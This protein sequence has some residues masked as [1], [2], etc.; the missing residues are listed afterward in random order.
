MGRLARHDILFEPV[1]IGCKTLR[2]R[3]Y[4]VPHCTGFGVEKPWSQSRHRAVKAQGGWAAVCTEYCTIS[5]E[6]DETPFVSARM[7]DDHDLRMLSYTADQQAT[8][9]WK[10]LLESYEDPGIDP[11]I[12]AELQ[13]YIVRR[14]SEIEAE[15]AA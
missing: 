9:E 11:A 8:G 7:W 4:Q 15:N 1:P 14:R 5:P 2:N 3:F 10:R 13:E 12:D 6:A